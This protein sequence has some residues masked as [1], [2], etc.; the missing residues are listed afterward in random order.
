MSVTA[1][2]MLELGT[3][4]PEF[5]LP[6]TA[7]KKVALDDFEDAPA[8]LVIFMCNHCPFVIHLREHLASAGT[9]RGLQPMD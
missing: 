2:E 3:L 8:L 4:A 7:G 9:G 5:N 1:S 6:D